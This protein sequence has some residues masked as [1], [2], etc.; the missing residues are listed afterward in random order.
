[1]EETT[2]NYYIER[3]FSVFTDGDFLSV[4]R[5]TRVVVVHYVELK[6]FAYPLMGGKTPF[7]HQALTPAP[8][9]SSPI[10]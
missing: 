1:M 5:H 8:D 9:Y 6:S 10:A 2:G 3:N 4:V 7:T